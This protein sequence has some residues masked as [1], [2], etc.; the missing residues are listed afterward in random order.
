[1]EAK[2]TS[3]PLPAADRALAR[4]QLLDLRQHIEPDARAAAERRIIDTIEAWVARYCDPGEVLGVYWA[5]R[6]EPVLLEAYRRW[7]AEGRVLA[8]PRVV[9][10]DQPLMFGRWQPDGRLVEAAFGVHEPTPFEPVVPRWLIMPCVGFDPR[11]YRL[12]YGGGFYD[13]T[14]AALGAGGIGVAFE[15]TRVSGFEPAP[16]DRPL[17]VLVTDTQL[18]QWPQIRE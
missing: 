10:R 14:M 13:R 16:H 9:A 3:Y 6:G 8:L 5:M 4:R 15:V 18:R 7:H 17:R 2:S 11:G 1:M 12:G